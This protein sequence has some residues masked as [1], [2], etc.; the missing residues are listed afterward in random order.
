MSKRAGFLKLLPTKNNSLGPKPPG[1]SDE[2][3]NGAAP[4]AFP[5]ASTVPNLPSAMSDELLDL[6]AFLFFQ[7]GFHHVGM[8]FEQF[9]LVVATVKLAA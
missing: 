8:T 4:R 3:V 6:Y 7:G 5:V 2:S 1:S 9:L